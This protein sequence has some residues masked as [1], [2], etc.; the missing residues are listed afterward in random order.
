MRKGKYKVHFS[1]KSA[2]GN[3]KKIVYEKP[4]L[5]N[6]EEDP[7]ELYNIAEKH[8]DIVMELTKVAQE[9]KN[10]FVIAESIFDLN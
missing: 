9:H 7:G 4:I 8:Q 2:Y 1:Y 5:Y 6:I 3:D 10:S